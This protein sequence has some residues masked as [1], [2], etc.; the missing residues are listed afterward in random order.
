MRDRVAGLAAAYERAELACDALLRAE[1]AAFARW[2]RA[3][4]DTSVARERADAAW[5]AYRAA[6]CR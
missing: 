5:A 2:E 1:E 6:V 4:L 3:A